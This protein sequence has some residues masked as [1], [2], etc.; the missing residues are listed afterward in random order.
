MNPAVMSFVS[1]DP[2]AI[3]NR[4]AIRRTAAVPT[5]SLLVGPIGAGGRTWRRW[6]AATGRSV[7]VANRNLFPLAEWVRSV[8]DRVDLP[9]GAVRCL[10]RRAERDSAE[11]LAAWLV[12]TP[13]DR[14]RFF[15]TVAPNA[16]DELL[17]TVAAL[18]AGRGSG[19][20]AAAALGDLGEPVVLMI[21]RL[22]PSAVWPSVL[23]VAGS[24]EDFSAV[25]PAAERWATRVPA[26]P[27]AVA[28]PAG[29]W[30]EFLAA[31]AE[32]RAKALLKEGEI[33]VPVMDLATVERTLSEAGA[34]GS[35]AAAL[36]ASG[37]DP[38][39]VEAA[40]GVVR[41]TVAPPTTQV[42][43]DRARSAAEGFLFEFL[44]TLPE[45][46][47][48]FE[49]N[50]SLDFHF[51]PRLAEVDFLCRS[52]RIAIELDGYFHFVAP[53][54]YRSDRTKDWELQR[55]GFLVLRFLAEDVIPRLEMIRDRILDAL[56]VNP[57]G[58][59]P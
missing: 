48:R 35:A 25:A 11:F 2:I 58:A 50:A 17:R 39:L 26:V 37:A 23:F 40:V 36:A 38:A 29:V 12:K 30:D 44:E 7:V 20:A 42:E 10:A 22:V 51:G 27:V 34:A 5:V 28:V 9:A 33:R 43:D 14:E 46:A 53:D 1:G 18:A 31:A 8:A 4:H 24:T 32:S 57:H 56:T 6:A 21:V 59:Q 13:A 3:L 54:G 47:G 52:R 19:S 45:T 41:A 55:R 49:L 16:D 15:S